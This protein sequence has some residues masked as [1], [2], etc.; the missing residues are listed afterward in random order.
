MELV[1]RVAEDRLRP[2]VTALG[3]VVRN[4]FE[5]RASRTRR[6]EMAAPRCGESN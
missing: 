1:V 3:H 5:D 6:V 4:L 2:A